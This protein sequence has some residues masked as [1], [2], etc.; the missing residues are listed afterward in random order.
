MSSSVIYWDYLFAPL[1]VH[2]VTISGPD[3][4]FLCLFSLV[5]RRRHIKWQVFKEIHKLNEF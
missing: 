2:N 5:S 1:S 3:G 4:I